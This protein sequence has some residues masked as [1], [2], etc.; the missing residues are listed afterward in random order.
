MLFGQDLVEDGPSTVATHWI[1]F[2]GP[3]A[4]LFRRVIGTAVAKG[5]VATM[6]GLK[7]YVEARAR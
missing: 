6:A 5:L 7:T 2:S 1:E 4:F 3:L